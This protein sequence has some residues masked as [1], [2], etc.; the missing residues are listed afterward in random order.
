MEE[1]WTIKL[2]DRLNPTTGKDLK[3]SNP[4]LGHKWHAVNKD[5]FGKII[6]DPK[7]EHCGNFK[8]ELIGFQASAWV[9]ISCAVYVGDENAN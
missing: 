1:A 7:C 6:E 9:C 3:K 5:V 2:S 8:S 4:L